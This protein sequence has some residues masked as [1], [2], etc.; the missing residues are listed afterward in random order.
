MGGSSQFFTVLL[1][2][3]EPDGRHQATGRRDSREYPGQRCQQH[4][5]Q[6]Q[7][8]QEQAPR[9]HGKGN[10]KHELQK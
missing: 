1:G 8:H 2:L 6:Q 10:H 9:H 3:G 5:H 4:H 7:Q